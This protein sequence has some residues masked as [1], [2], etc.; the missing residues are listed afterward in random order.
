MTLVWQHKNVQ[1]EKMTINKV[2]HDMHLTDDQ[3]DVN[4]NGENK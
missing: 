3:H 1:E 2:S 4:I